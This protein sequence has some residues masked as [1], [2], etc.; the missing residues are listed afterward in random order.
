[1]SFR[2]EGINLPNALTLLRIFLVP[3]LV[4]AIL[5]VFEGRQWVC[6][7]VFLVAALTDALDGFIARRRGQVTTLGRLL[8]PLADKLLIC[9][10]LVSLVE[11][12]LAPGWMV[13]VIL[14]REFAI[15]GLRGIAAERGV[16]ISARPWGK[17]KMLIQVCCIVALLLSHSP[18]P[19]KFEQLMRWVG[20]LLLW[21]TVVVSAVSGMDYLF[22]FRR[23]FTDDP[24]SGSGSPMAD[25]EAA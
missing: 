8:D 10:A 7:G 5:A 21:G 6:A 16:T 2:E 18:Q 12:R 23:V 11:V 13:V 19:D 3:V 24:S 20:Q 9:G 22:E 1:M 14:A 17:V 25:G 4:A 15:T